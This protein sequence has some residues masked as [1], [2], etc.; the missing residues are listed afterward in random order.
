MKKLFTKIFGAFFLVIISIVILVLVLSF[1]SI[2]EHYL[3]YLTNDLKSLD[4]VVQ[5][6]VQ[7]LLIQNK[8]SEID[9]MVKVLGKNINTRI[10]IITSNGEVI[11]DS[12]IDPHSMENH[13]TRPE[14]IQARR[15]NFGQSL[16]FSK[17][18]NE[19]MLYVSLP[20]KQNNQIIGFS[21]L[22]LFIS[23]INNLLNDLKLKI[24]NITL[25]VSAIALIA[26]LIFTRLLVYPLKKFTA[27]AKKVAA[28][29]FDTKVILNNKDEMQ[30]LATSFNYMTEHIKDLFNQLSQE[31]E[32]LTLI[33]S[34]L[35][36]SFVVFN[37]YGKIILANDS[38]GKI[39]N[40]EIMVGK[41]YWEL[42]DEPDFTDFI[43]HIQENRTNHSSEV[44]IGEQHYLCSAN[45][46]QGKEE[47]TLILYDITQLKKLEKIKRDF[48]VNVSHELRTP[49][50]A[51]KGFIETLEEEIDDTNRHYVE[52]I[53]RHTDRLINI[54]Q[55]L[56]LLSKLEHPDTKLEITE[57]DISQSLT[58]IIPLFNDKIKDKDLEI[59][60]NIESKFPYLHADEFK[61]E[62]VLINLID[63]AV[64]YT[65]KGEV[66]I[67]IYR[68]ASSSVIEISDT[69]L[70]MTKEQKD[71]IFERFYVVDKSRSRKVGGTGLGLA[72][73]KHIVMLHNGDINVESEKGSGT[74]FTVT[75]PDL[76][77]TDE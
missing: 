41:Y 13:S 11:A 59:K 19:E 20:I 6:S 67:N 14:I 58:H 72:I 74:K 9:S 12:K 71:R 29:D 2:K 76:I 45:F 75:L 43:K 22:S 73:V 15:E 38:F 34:S 52:I 27:A 70:G 3:K 64:K 7:P 26:V 50:T 35:Q 51:I 8:Y 63:N 5:I 25:F 33:I 23:D 18:V 37:I 10:T 53:H 42:I 4:E 57:Y 46:L 32:K 56:L 48:V 36:E 77:N 68:K 55:D 39:V 49:L 66:N 24:R 40:S 44:E 62:Q 30:D 69:G 1:S 28:G 61:I 21:R 31:K 17:T 47:F 65:D 16:R 60:V 54:V